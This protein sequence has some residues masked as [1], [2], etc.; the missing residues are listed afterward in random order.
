MLDGF[1]TPNSAAFK[2]KNLE[3]FAAPVPPA[4]SRQRG[5]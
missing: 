3:I 5:G 2:L 4:P 1:F